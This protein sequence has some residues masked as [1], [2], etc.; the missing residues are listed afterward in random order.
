MERESKM[1][2][3]HISAHLL[4]VIQTAMTVLITVTGLGLYGLLNTGCVLHPARLH[5]LHLSQRLPRRA[6]PHPQEAVSS[7]DQ[8]LRDQ[9]RSDD[10]PR[11]VCHQRPAWRLAGGFNVVVS[12]AAAGSALPRHAD[13]PQPSH[14]T[15]HARDGALRVRRRGVHLAD[16]ARVRRRRH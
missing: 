12:T 11:D 15:G 16:V 3:V 8:Q 7:S 5:D 6:Q 1:A 14:S 9:R 10:E 2:E 4:R 13:H